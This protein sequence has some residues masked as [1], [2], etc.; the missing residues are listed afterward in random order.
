[1]SPK[2]SVQE[3]RARDSQEEMGFV[4][5]PSQCSVLGLETAPGCFPGDIQQLNST[6]PLEPA[7]L[8]QA[9]Q[10]CTDLLSPSV[11]LMRPQAAPISG[12]SSF[13]ASSG[14]SWLLAFAR[15]ETSTL[16]AKLSNVSQQNCSLPVLTG[17]NLLISSAHG[18]VPSHIWQEK[19]LF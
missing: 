2:S 14:I 10:P 12:Q 7:Q 8:S 19:A 4:C 5:L 16:L 13:R 6:A 17:N 9:R 1:M 11:A 18:L 3:P 15:W